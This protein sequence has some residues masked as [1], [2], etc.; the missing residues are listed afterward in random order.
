MVREWKNWAL[1]SLAALSLFVL[2]LIAAPPAMALDHRDFV[3]S[4]E[5]HDFDFGCLAALST[6]AAVAVVTEHDPQSILPER[7]PLNVD[8]IVATAEARYKL[9]LDPRHRSAPS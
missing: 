4:I 1:R 7:L 3:T 5:L 9:Q 2:P 8:T 6:R